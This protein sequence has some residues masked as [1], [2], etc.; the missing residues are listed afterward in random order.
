MLSL[1]LAILPQTP[2]AIGT[3]D[4]VS[5]LATTGAA[6]KFELPGLVVD[7][8]QMV[9]LKRRFGDRALMQGKIRVDQG[10]LTVI[11]AYGTVQ[12]SREWREVLMKGKL[13]GAG[14]F[15]VGSTA[16]TEQI[17]E[18]EKPY[19][20]LGW[21]AFLTMGDTCF[22]F[23]MFTLAKANESPIKRADLDRMLMSARFAIVRLGHWEDM[24]PAV[25]DRMHEG[26]T[27][28]AGDG[29]AWLMGL[30]PAAPDGWACA[31]AAAEIGRA[32]SM[33]AHDRIALYDRVLAD[34]KPREGVPADPTKVE[35]PPNSKGFVELTAES[36]RAM[37]LRDD[38]QLEAALAGVARARALPGAETPAAKTALSYDAATI[39][40]LKKDAAAAVLNLRESFAGDPDRRAFATHE[41]AFAPIAG[42]KA[43]IALIKTGK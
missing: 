40:A 31:L 43:L 20:D 34:L 27:R 1:L 15:D 4:V 29:P 23:G 42:D 9:G 33:T 5:H 2:A 17:R 38:G 12:S 28:P 25:L 6:V 22:D 3:D 8:A 24:P 18:L 30:A 36:G 41:A 26:L 37:A 10:S 7:S 14:Q 32:M 19:A 35:V 39:H 21:H 16:C 11:A 13:V